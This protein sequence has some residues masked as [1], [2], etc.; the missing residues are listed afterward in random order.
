MKIAKDAVLDAVASLMRRRFGL[1]P[2]RNKQFVLECADL[3]ALLRNGKA[4]T[5][6]RTPK[7][8]TVA[9]DL[10][11]P[12]PLHC[13]VQ[14]DDATHCTRE[15]AETFANYPADTPLNFDVRRYHADQAA[16]DAALAQA[17]ML[18]DLLPAKH[19]LNPTVRIRHD[20]I[21]E[22][23]GPLAE[24]IESLLSKRFAFHAGTTFHLMI[25]NAGAKPH[26]THGA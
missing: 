2:E 20:E 1:E 13:I 14:F 23:T 11:F 25:E 8:V 3:S 9:A 26:R 5:S 17:D 19:G 10:Y 22:L 18:A 4:G 7:Q 6:S 21:D 24:R 16:G 12:A 15:R